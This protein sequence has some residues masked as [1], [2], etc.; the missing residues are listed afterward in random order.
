MTT[1]SCLPE[2]V[3]HTSRTQQ[4]KLTRSLCGPLKFLKFTLVILIT[5]DKTIEAE[6]TNYNDKL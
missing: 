3:T 4:L 6:L 1:V 5:C 2:Q